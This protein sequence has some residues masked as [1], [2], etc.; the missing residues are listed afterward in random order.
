MFFSVIIYNIIDNQL[1]IDKCLDRSGAWNYP[2]GFC[3]T[4]NN[5]SIEE[6]K[7]LS[8]H[9]NWNQEKRLCEGL[10]K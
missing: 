7:C 9:G 10:K 3:V 5:I 6:I 1:E 4:D 8:K 2:K